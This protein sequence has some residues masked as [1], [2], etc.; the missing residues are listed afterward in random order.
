MSEDLKRVCSNLGGQDVAYVFI[1]PFLYLAGS[2]ME[3]GGSTGAAT[4]DDV[5]SA[6]IQITSVFPFCAVMSGVH[7]NT[8]A[9][10]CTSILLRSMSRSSEE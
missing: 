3:A 10:A 4:F 2:W 7:C 5:S 6:V 9:C 1:R 8:S